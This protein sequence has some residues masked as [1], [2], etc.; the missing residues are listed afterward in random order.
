MAPVVPEQARLGESGVSAEVID[1]RS[2]VPLDA[3]TILGPASRTGGSLPH[4]SRRIHRL[5]G[6]GC[7]DRLHRREEGFWDL[8][9]PI[10]RMITPH[11]PLD[12]FAGLEDLTTPSVER[13]VETER[14]SA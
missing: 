9:G 13:V 1:L 8:D 2:L 5:R 6:L 10:V 14:A 12:S 11:I 3:K 7:R 4:P